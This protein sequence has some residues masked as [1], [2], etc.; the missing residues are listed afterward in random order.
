[1]PGILSRR[2]LSFV[3]WPAARQTADPCDDLGSFQP[4]V[5]NCCPLP[6]LSSD[7]KGMRDG[8]TTRIQLHW[9]SVMRCTKFSLARV[10]LFDRKLRP[11]FC[12]LPHQ[13]FGCGF[14]H[15]TVQLWRVPW[16]FVSYLNEQSSSVAVQ[17]NGFLKMLLFLRNGQWEVC[18]TDNWVWSKPFIFPF[19]FKVNMSHFCFEKLESFW[20]SLVLTFFSNNTYYYL[21][22]ARS[23]HCFTFILKRDK[24]SNK[25]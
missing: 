11:K 23:P 16:W 18:I 4:A 24:W 25:R 12:D 1:M 5:S 21:N 14:L 13:Q 3:C 22:K 9:L 15:D 2:L 6:S 8:G 17:G 7:R 20:R 19:F 10:Y